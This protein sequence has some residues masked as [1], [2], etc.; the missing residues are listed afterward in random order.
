MPKGKRQ[1]LPP[2][3]LYAFSCATTAPQNGALLARLSES[4]INDPKEGAAPVFGSLVEYSDGTECFMGRPD[5]RDDSARIASHLARILD[6]RVALTRVS[7]NVSAY[8]SAEGD[9]SDVDEA[10]PPGMISVQRFAIEPNGAMRSESDQLADDEHYSHGDAYETVFELLNTAAYFD[11]APVRTTPV[12]GYLPTEDDGLPQ[13]LSEIRT[14]IVQA[15]K[16]EMVTVGG[17]RMLCVVGAN[18]VKRFA[19]VSPEELELLK[20]S[21][22]VSPS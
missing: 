16:Y 8:N 20:N 12:M 2:E 22:H 10:L 17:R 14:L 4:L 5:T 19:A 21:T 6:A 13:R 3:Y 7:L 1:F 9:E 18:G 15:G 11:S